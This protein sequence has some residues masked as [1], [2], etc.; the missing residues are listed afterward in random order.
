MKYN[1]TEKTVIFD[2]YYQIK[3][4]LCQWKEK[5]DPVTET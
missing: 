5:N 3:K 1:K 2:I 4:S